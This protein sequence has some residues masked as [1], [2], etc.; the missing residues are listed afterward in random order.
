MLR[1]LNA[2]L[3]IFLATVV[4]AQ[5]R[6]PI[7][8]H[9]TADESHLLTINQTSHS[10]S[11]VQLPGGTVRHELAVGEHPASATLFD[12][13]RQLAVACAYSGELMLLSIDPQAGKLTLTATI[14]IGMEPRSVAVD[15]QA[16]LAYV[17]RWAADQVAVVDLKVNRVIDQI[18]VPGQPRNIAIAPNGKRLAVAVDAERGLSIVDLETREVAFTT[19]FAAMNV[20]LLRPSDDSKY[21]YFPWMVYRENPITKTNIR[22]G[23]VLASRLAR[24]RLDVEERREAFSLDPE[25]RAVAD[26]YAVD[27]SGNGRRIVVTSPGTHELLVFAAEGLPWESHGSSDHIIDEL[28]HNKERFSRIELGGRP[29]GVKLAADNRTAY[30]ANY[31]RNSVQVV[32]IETGKLTGEF[33]LGSSEVQSSSRRG[34]AL[35]HDAQRSFEQWY[36][37]HSCHRDGGGNVKPID[38][39]NDGSRFTFKTVLPLYHVTQT[40]PWTWHGWQDDLRAAMRKSLTDTMLGPEPSEADVTDLIAYMHELEAPPNP[41]RAA[42]QV[43]T[44]RTLPDSIARGKQIFASDAAGCINCHTGSHFTDGEIHDVGTGGAGD[45]YEG[46]NTPSLLSVYRKARLL[47]DGS[48]ASLAEVLRGAHA[49]QQVAGERAL[50][51][52]ELLDL[53]AYLKTL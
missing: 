5:D 24:Q 34:E 18:D 11:L 30:I 20:G 14:P 19:R 50:S 29:L 17:S 1:S 35:F 10:V 44:E 49:P 6:S 27:L 9:L 39:V 23:W 41:H 12:D 26:P 51:E 37:C 28:L 21:V 45:R 8:V 16:K 3:L 13:D 46:Y 7:E 53:I 40:R 42:A 22:R 43:S 31:Q 33:P 25:G 38:T 32:D 15:W 47:H 52:Q 48:A 4:Q 36:S 2:L